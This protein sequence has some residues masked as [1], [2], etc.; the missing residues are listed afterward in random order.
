[1]DIYFELFPEIR[2]WHKN[3]LAQ[4]DRDGYL[5]N[6]FGYVLRFNHVYEHEK[7]GGVWQKRPGA[8]A[9][10]AIAFLPQSTAAGIIKEAM[11]RLY[12]ERFEEAGHCL[13]LLV[14]DELFMECEA[15]LRDSVDGVMKEEMEKPIPELALPASWEMGPYLSIDTEPK[16]GERWGKMH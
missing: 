14:H 16:T 6:P 10:E 15:G 2:T 12:Y 13:R 7:I 11:L 3:V 5:R 8:Q 1:M 9:N 4:A